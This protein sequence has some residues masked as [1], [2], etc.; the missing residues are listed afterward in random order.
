MPVTEALIGSAFVHRPAPVHVIDI[1]D[2]HWSGRLMPRHH[3]SHL[4]GLMDR[5]NRLAIAAITA[6]ATLLVLLTNASGVVPTPPR[7]TPLTPDGPAAT[8]SGCHIGFSAVGASFTQ[9]N[10]WNP[11]GTRL[12]DTGL[13]GSSWAYWTDADPDMELEGGWALAGQTTGDV[14]RHLRPEWFPEGTHL[15]ILLGT[16]DVEQRTPTDEIAP[17]LDHIADTA[18]VPAEKVLLVL[19]PPNNQAPGATRDLNAE[20]T[21]IATEREWALLDVGTAMG[22]GQGWFREGA[23]SDGT[24]LTEPWARF[25]GESVAAALRAEHCG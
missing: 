17:H 25:L 12:P 23:T 1:G 10:A 11:M 15:V 19:L 9:G 13:D 7:S 21:Q 14:A 6:F 2:N 18:G 3:T 24:H 20:L 16:N 5:T 4:G 8:D 22:D